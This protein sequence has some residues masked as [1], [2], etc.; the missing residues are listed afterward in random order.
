MKLKILTVATAWGSRHGGVNVFN[1]R[2]CC[3]LAKLGHKVTSYVKQYTAEDLIDATNQGVTLKAIDKP[4]DEKWGLDDI[5]HIKYAEVDDVDVLVVHDIVCKAFLDRFPR[6]STRPIVAAFIH[7]LYRDTDYFGGL[8]DDKRREKTEAQYAL[9]ESADVAFTSGSW[10]AEQLS[11][12]KPTLS[13]KIRPFIPGRLDIQ[14]RGG[15]GAACDVPACVLMWSAR[16]RGSRASGW[17]TPPATSTSTCER[18]S[19]RSHGNTLTG[20][21]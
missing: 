6:K 16:S 12:A 1:Y 14:P 8:S 13:A 17:T 11:S 21:L 5:G 7:T 3:G 2:M 10:M 18:P 4:S 19:C 9:I 20:G 15:P